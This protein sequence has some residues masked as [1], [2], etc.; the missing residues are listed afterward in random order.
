MD[1][2]KHIWLNVFVPSAARDMWRNDYFAKLWY[3]WS[4][5]INSLL[6][7]PAGF[8]GISLLGWRGT[9]LHPEGFVLSCYFKNRFAKETLRGE[10]RV[11]QHTQVEAG[12]SN[13]AHWAIFAHDSS[14]KTRQFYPRT[15]KKNLQLLD[16]YIF[17]AGPSSFPVGPLACLSA[18]LVQCG[19]LT[20]QFVQF[21]VVLFFL[22]R[23]ITWHSQKGEEQTGT[24]LSLK[25]CGKWAFKFPTCF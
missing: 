19:K 18:S 7:F 6:L 16:K 21:A 8:S 15:A 9:G 17:G 1:D 13:W 20:L 10:N 5:L 24:K 14:V 3:I 11:F 2:S 12:I 23:S 25:V 22:S 4:L